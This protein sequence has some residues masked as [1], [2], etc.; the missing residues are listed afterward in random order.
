MK[1]KILIAEDN[2][3]VNR[4]LRLLL[5]PLYKTIPAINGKQ[6]VDIATA[7]LPDL[8]LMDIIMPVINGFQATRLIRRNPKTRS[9]PI[10]AV[11]ALDGHIY[12]EECFQC[13]CNDHIAK[14]FTT[15]DLFPCIEKLL[16]QYSGNL[17]TLPS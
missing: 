3:A 12:E 6:A 15:Q 8:I 2:P 16:K 13:G 5:N 17:S 14:P 1:K 4:V 11:T 10:I 9:I 7:Q